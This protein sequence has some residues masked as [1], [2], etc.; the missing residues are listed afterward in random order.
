MTESPALALDK[1][2][3]GFLITDAERKI[4]YASQYFET[5]FGFHL[6][7]LLG[8]SLLGL[9]SRASTIMCESYVLPLLLHEQH[10]E[11]IQLVMLNPAGEE[12][13]V[14]I[15]AVVENERQVYW[16][17]Y[18]ATQ[19]D[20]LY[21]DLVEARRSLEDKA[22]KLQVL[23]ATDE[24]TGL[25]N[26]R[27]ML[28]QSR[29]II[30]GAQRERRPVSILVLDIDN[31][32]E[33]NDGSGHAAGDTV[34]KELG[35]LLQ[36]Y[37]R[38]SDVIARFGGDEFVCLLPDTNADAARAFA[39]R[40]HQ[41]VSQVEI[42]EP[43]VTVSMGLATETNEIDFARLFQKADKALYEAKSTG[44]GKSVVAPAG[45]GHM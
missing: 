41:L 6:D 28:R 34:L 1:F 43:A 15:N 45:N 7:A 14:I 39:S 18:S 35:Q 10:C 42:G 5:R 27:E 2:P 16:T 8:S 20:K 33:I 19:R 9:L 37:G 30:A 23:S 21:Q 36:R 13:P 29:S 3:A 44:R 25:F 22:A 26:R 11:E 24:L 40:L 38:A 17:V 4:V 32:K 31:F 12:I